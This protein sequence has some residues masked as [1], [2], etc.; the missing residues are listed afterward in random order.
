MEELEDI[1]NRDPMLKDAFNQGVLDTAV[2]IDN[3]A[4]VVGTR[5]KWALRVSN[6]D[7]WH[8]VPLTFHKALL[9]MEGLVKVIRDEDHA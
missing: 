9:L 5:G 2:Q 1:I 6:G 3:I 4:M 8:D 7:K